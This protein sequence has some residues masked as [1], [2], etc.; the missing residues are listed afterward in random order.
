MTDTIHPADWQERFEKSARE[1]EAREK[2]AGPKRPVSRVQLAVYLAYEGN[3]EIYQRN[4]P[5]PDMFLGAWGTINHLMQEMGVVDSGFA[6]AT[7]RTEVEMR[8]LALTEDE[9]T[10]VLMWATVRKQK[11]EST[12]QALQEKMWL[13]KHEKK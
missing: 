4:R 10:R 1:Q 5:D 6:S 13:L 3:D 2:A 9:P 12:R 7:F 11:G 8:L